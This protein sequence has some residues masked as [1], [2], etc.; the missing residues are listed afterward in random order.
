MAK[1][2]IRMHSIIVF[3][4]DDG[5]ISCRA[6]YEVGSD[7]LVESR[8]FVPTLSDKQEDAIKEFGADILAQIKALEEN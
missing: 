5:G 4:A 1:T 7:D 8:S 6:D 2:V 3:R